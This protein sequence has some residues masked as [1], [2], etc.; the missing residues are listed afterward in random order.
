[1]MIHTLFDLG[2]QSM[3]DVLEHGNGPADELERLRHI[4]DHAA[5]LLP[6]QGPI[7][8]FIHHNT[9][10]AF[11]DLT[12]DQGVQKGA[13]VFGCHAYLPEERFRQHLASGRIRVADLQGALAEDLGTRANEPIL[14]L[15]TRFDLRMAML[16]H[17]KWTAPQA[18]LHWFVAQTDALT[19]FRPE[20]NAAVRERLLVETRHWVMRDLRRLN[21]TEASR[22]TPIQESLANLIVSFGEKDLELWTDVKWEA[23]TLQGRWKISHEAVA[24][25]SPA[26]PVRH[27]AARPRDWLLQAT[28]QDCDL[29]VNEVLIRFCSAF[30]DQGISQWPLPKREQGFLKAF[31]ALYSRAGGPPNRWLRDLPRELKR[32]E[33]A[34]M[35]TLESIHESLE[36]LGVPHDQWDDYIISSF[37][38]LPGWAGMIRQMEERADRVAHGAPPGSLVEYLAVRLILERLAA[39][40]TARDE[41]DFRGPLSE[42]RAAMPVREFEERETSDQR[43]FLVFQLAQVLG[44]IPSDLWK[45]SRSEWTRLVEEIEAFPNL[46]RRRVFQKAFERRYRNQ[47]LDAVSA[48]SSRPAT[49]GKPKYQ[50]VCCLDEREESF[51]RHLEELEPEVET[52]GVAGFYSVAM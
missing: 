24:D 7:T 17:P 21:G 8:V 3:A 41:L 31:T 35:S 49:S 39:A 2:V 4:I 28:G 32:I 9:L 13:E 26:A 46:E 48:L 43:A 33:L 22:P 36:L 1:M 16:Q 20:V 10:H 42:L 11:E 30:L 40:R 6:A 19:K 52:F 51:R 27:P 25:L 47:A 18:E 5:H 50:V 12:F 44:W 23:F 34:G 38:A 37:L 29:C 45:L 14:L 15:G